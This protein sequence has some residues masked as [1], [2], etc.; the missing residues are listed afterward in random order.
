LSFSVTFHVVTQAD[1][2]L[3]KIDIHCHI[4]GDV[5]LEC[6]STDAAQEREEM[7]FRVMFNTAFI[8]SNI[9][10]LNRDEIDLMWDA[11]DRFAK[12]FRAEVCNIIAHNLTFTHC[13]AESNA[14]FA[15][16]GKRFSFQKWTRQMN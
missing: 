14:L 16:H 7:M 13:A 6:I 4:Q 1:C 12:E 3:I 11:K 2:E 10:M 9:L 15:F 5:V 8:R